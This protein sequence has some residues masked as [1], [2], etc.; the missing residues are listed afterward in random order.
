MTEEE[1]KQIAQI[2]DHKL[3]AR[4]E[5]LEAR[6]AA[7]ATELKDAQASEFKAQATKLDA[8]REDLKNLREDPKFGLVAQS[9]ELKAL[10]EDFNKL[11]SQFDT[12][13]I[14]QDAMALHMDPRVASYRRDD[15]ILGLSLPNT[16]APRRSEGVRMRNFVL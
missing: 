12:M 11:S 1:I 4:F 16:S 14:R 6:L 2:I 3:D 5:T 9:N 8:Q 15:H 10:R 7:Q 13:R